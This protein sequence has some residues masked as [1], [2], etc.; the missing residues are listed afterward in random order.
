MSVDKDRLQIKEGISGGDKIC[1]V[2][3]FEVLDIIGDYSPTYT[4]TY[5]PTYEDKPDSD[6]PRK[7]R[8]CLRRILETIFGFFSSGEKKLNKNTKR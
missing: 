3:P 4:P 2:E 7:F 6:S 1:T 5:T 8:R